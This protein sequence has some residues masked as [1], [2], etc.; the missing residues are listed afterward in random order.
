MKSNFIIT[1]VIICTSLAVIYNIGIGIIS[2]GAVPSVSKFISS[3]QIL[4]I[5]NAT[6]SDTIS[7][8]T[9]DSI[10]NPL[11]QSGLMAST[12][13]KTPR[14]K[15]HATIADTEELQNRGLGGRLSMPEQDGML[16][17]FPTDLVQNFWMKDMNFP[18]DIV[19][20]NASKHVTGVTSNIATSTYPNLFSSPSA[21]RY[22]LELNAGSASRFGLKKGVQVSF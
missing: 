15:I 2:S 17:I 16:F 4:D 6:S 19:W 1:T 20:I 13:I 11:S 9:P 18:I 21:V 10:N 14:S 5:K 3:N 7:S 8:S 22:V 12:T